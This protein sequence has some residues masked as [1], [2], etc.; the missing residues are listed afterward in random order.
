M[1]DSR[2]P[3][4]R[5]SRTPLGDATARVN[6]VPSV[7]PLNLKPTQALVPQPPPLNPLRAH[8]TTKSTSHHNGP[9]T[10]PAG[11][12]PGSS[13]SNTNAYASGVPSD[14]QEDSKRDS[15]ISTTSTTSNAKRRKTHIGPWELGKTLGNGSAARV[16]LVRHKATGQ[17]AAVKILSRNAD[18][19]TQPGSIAA[20]DKWDRGREEYK[21]ENRIPFAIEREVAIMKLIDHPNIVKLFDIWENRSEIYLVLEYVQ[22]GDL[23]S[24][25]AKRGRLAEIEAIFLFRQ[26][27]SALEYVHSF[28]ICHRDLKPE[29]ILITEELQVKITDFGMSALHQSPSHM[30]RTS[31]GSPHYAAPELIGVGSYRGDTADIWSLGIILYACLANTLPF[32]DDSIPRLLLKIQKGMYR[33]PSYLS[34]EAQD[35]IGRV[36]VVDPEVR[37]CTQEMW[38]HPLLI[39]YDHLDNLNDGGRAQKYRQSARCEPVPPEDLDT[40]TLRQLKSVWHTYTE[41]QL[42]EKLISPEH[43][44][45]KR[46]YWLLCSYRERRLENY[47]TELAHS[48]SDYHHLQPA[49]WAKK[50]TTVEFPAQHGR[51]MSR[52]TVISNVATDENGEAIERDSIDAVATVQSYDPYKSSRVMGDI[53]ASRANIII[54]RNGTTSTRASKA[55]SVRAGSV[56]TNST[57]SRRAKSGRHAK[58]PY[59]PRGSKRSL[60]SIRSGEEI[61]YKRPVSRRKRRTDFSRSGKRS[62]NQVEAGC[63]PAS[64]GKIGTTRDQEY[65]ASAS[66]SKKPGL[67]KSSG[68]AHTRRRS[69]TEAEDAG[70]HWNEELRLFSRSIAKDCDDAFNSTLL[71]QQSPV[72]DT[73]SLIAGLGTPTLTPTAQGAGPANANVQLWDSRP[74]PPAPA[75]KDLDMREYTSA[76]SAERYQGN[77]L[78]SP[79]RL[80]G[81]VEAER[82]IVSAPIYSQYSTQWGKDVIPLPS[83]RE[84]PREYN[85]HDDGDRVRVVSAPPE[86]PAPGNTQAKAG[87]DLEHLAQHGNTI[88]L[89]DTLSSRPSNVAA[90]VTP[91]VP[92]GLSL[93]LQPKSQLTLRQQYVADGMNTT[94]LGEY[95]SPF[96]EDSTPIVKKKASWFKRSSKDKDDIFN[97]TGS[98]NSDGLNRTETNSSTD[99][100]AQPK[101]KGFLSF[102]R[103]SKEE[104]QLKFSLGGPDVDD[105][106]SPKP[107]RMFSHPSRPLHDKKWKE[108]AATRNIVPHQSWL[109]RLF[110][111]KPATRYLCFAIP[112]RRVR[113]EIAILLKEWRRHGMRDI[114]VDKERNLVFARVAKKNDLNVKE[115]SFAAEIMTVIEHGKRNQL[116]IVRFTQERGA[117]TTFHK[118]IDTMD[119][120]FGSRGL[121]VTDKFK[122]KM[123]IKTLNS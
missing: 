14:I 21:S 93:G 94:S 76:K 58:A 72:S 121:L 47:G 18:Y 117:A 87:V 9:S 107:M 96:G 120:I 24:Y 43:N 102:W 51:N 17:L 10:G 33:M 115:A 37:L 8:P 46:F 84:T 74:L 52:F 86:S 22:R 41:N 5:S 29:N 30:L 48:A 79:D 25:L 70:F 34:A 88:R 83:I 60:N 110:R 91:N 106:P 7:K 12:K 63:R 61:S 92:E 39:K 56:R 85:R 118:V 49:N 38:Q 65:T 89:V 90:P 100:T 71:S 44:E 20:L 28:N 3:P 19:N 55:P 57:Y 113:Q 62:V 50:Y 2:G 45:F 103:G 16:R 53:V 59:T 35:L 105:P 82:R 27:I 114:V 1:A 13:R 111:V 75:S 64:T 109:A 68:G 4:S 23:Y 99:T 112:R 95:A 36:L 104:S 40:P 116:C 119:D 32:N 67:S 54:H 66:P 26:M 15:H 42:A 6:N 123:M 78:Q 122:A 31:C 80:S 81:K 11:T 98:G 73:G 77:T 108:K 101:K 69:M 97:R